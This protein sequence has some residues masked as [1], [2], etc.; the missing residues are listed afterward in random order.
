MKFI[1]CKLQ[2]NQA[3]LKKKKIRNLGSTSHPLPLTCKM[4]L[5]KTLNLCFD[6]FF[7]NMKLMRPVLPLLLLRQENCRGAGKIYMASHVFKYVF[8]KYVLNVCVL[9]MYFHI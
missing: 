6:F 4:T 2:L 5:D 1:V 3:D 9:N 7:Y 8:I